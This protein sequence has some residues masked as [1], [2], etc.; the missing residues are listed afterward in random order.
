[1]HAPAAHVIAVSNMKKRNCD[2]DLPAEA[3]LGAA[4]VV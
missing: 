4:G 3:Y 1:M 2:P